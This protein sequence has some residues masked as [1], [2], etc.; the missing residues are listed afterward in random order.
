MVGSGFRPCLGLP[1]SGC[2]G[3][4]AL[5]AEAGVRIQPG[6]AL[7]AE[8]CGNW[9]RWSGPRRRC[10]LS[11]GHDRVRGQLLLHFADLPAGS[12]TDQ[13]EQYSQRGHRQTNHHDQQHRAQVT[14]GT[15][16]GIRRRGGRTRCRRRGGT[17]RGAAGGTR[18]LKAQETARHSLE[19]QFPAPLLLAVG[20][21]QRSRVCHD[22]LIPTSQK[23]H[24]H[25]D[26]T[27]RLALE[28]GISHHPGKCR[29]VIG[30]AQVERDHARFIRD[31]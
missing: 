18:G 1:L 7:V 17:G 28:E 8:R 25:P 24:L 6:T 9:G 2:R 23:G 3:S 15:G 4:P 12:P 10:Y 19:N 26:R 11:R 31:C 13:E 14:A 20:I 29:C 16:G 5:R 30:P 27:V 22:H 21:H